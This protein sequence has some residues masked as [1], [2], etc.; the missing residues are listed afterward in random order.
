[1]SIIDLAV[2]PLT[3]LVIYSVGPVRQYIHAEALLHHTHIQDGATS[4]HIIPEN[5]M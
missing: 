2:I 4:N 1:M 5:A 3:A